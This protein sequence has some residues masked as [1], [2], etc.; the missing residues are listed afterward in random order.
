MKQI[1]SIF[2]PALFT[3]AAFCSVVYLSCSKSKCG[4]VVCQNGGTCTGNK[5]VCA[6]GYSGNGCQSGWSDE[7]LG[8]YKCKRGSCTP[9]IADTSSWQ[10]VITKDASNSG[11]TIDISSFAQGSASISAQ[12]DS[13]GNITIS[14]AAGSAGVHATGKYLN[15]TITMEYTTA[16][17][18]GTTFSCS[19][20]M[21]KQ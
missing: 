14:P 9:A 15:G 7:F 21:V 3:L 17:A 20:V 4:G 6:A 2:I 13:V 18:V 1:R 10:S 8:T 11:Y 12:V 19:M 5:C 16:A